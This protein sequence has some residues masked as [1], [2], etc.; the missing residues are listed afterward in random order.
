[1][2]LKLPK[3]VGPHSAWMYAVTRKLLGLDPIFRA[4][5]GISMSLGADG[6]TD[7]KCTVSPT[8]STGGF[9]E[10]Y[11]PWHS[12]SEG[13][14]FTIATG[15]VVTLNSIVVSPG[16]WAINKAGTDFDG[17]KWTGFLRANPVLVANTVATLPAIGESDTLF[18]AKQIIAYC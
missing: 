12:Y 18:C 16:V 10:E 4:G 13:E 6:I 2:P 7:I 11:D 3:I 15:R 9:T 1:M 8:A 5:K 14:I 17:N